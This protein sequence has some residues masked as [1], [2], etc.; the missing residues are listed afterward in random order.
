PYSV[1]LNLNMQSGS[2]P[3]YVGFG[4]AQKMFMVD[5]DLFDI[6]SYI[7]WELNDK[8]SISMQL[9][10]SDFTGGYSDFTK[11]M[12][13]IQYNHNISNLLTLSAGYRYIRNTSDLPQDP[14]LGYTGLTP[15]SQNYVAETFLVTVSTNFHSGAG[16]RRQRYTG[17]GGSTGFGLGSFGGYRASSPFGSSYEGYGY[18][19]GYT[20]GSSYGPGYG[21]FDNLRRSGEQYSQDR[22]PGY[23]IF[24]GGR[25][26]SRDYSEPHGGPQEGL[27]TGLGE[28]EAQERAPEIDRPQDGVQLPEDFAPERRPRP[29]RAPGAPPGEGYI[30]DI[31]TPFDPTDPSYEPGTSL[32]F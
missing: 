7:N 21:A 15:P 27:E 32:L 3:T 14:R 11:D 26:D 19:S 17:Y 12:C 5:N 20:G 28:F 23:G 10:K 24:E 2:S 31:D 8:S 6:Q 4:E 13:Q 25:D 18:D 9:G 22:L 1:G 16:G 29:P 30:P